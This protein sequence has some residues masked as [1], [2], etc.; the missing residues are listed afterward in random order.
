MARSQ[1]TRQADQ[2][3]DPGEQHALAKYE[4]QY[5]AAGRAQ[6]S[7]YSKL[8]HSFGDSAGEDA[9]NTDRGED[10]SHDPKRFE[11]R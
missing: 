11:Q 7:P 9:V 8:T 2:D 6:R 5:A 3:P 1:R 4:Y 10:Q